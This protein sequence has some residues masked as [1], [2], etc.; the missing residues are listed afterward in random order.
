VFGADRRDTIFILDCSLSM[1]DPID[2]KN[3][4]GETRFQAGRKALSE[5]L[6]VLRDSPSVD[7]ERDPYV[8]GFMA[9]GH[10]ARVRD[11]D[12]EKTRTN[13][14]WKL[15]I[16]ATVVDDWRNDFDLMTPPTRL[17]DDKYQQILQQLDMLQPYGETPL[18]GAIL[19][20][21][22][23]LVDRQR[24]GVVVAI[25]DGV[26]NDEGPNGP[27]LV[28]LEDLFKK[29]PELSLHLVAYGVDKPDDIAKL[30]MTATR[31][32]G[33]ISTAPSG[34][35]LARTI[36]KV[37]KPRQYSVARNVEPREEFFTDLGDPVDNRPPRTYEVRFPGLA[38]MPVRIVGGERLEF[39]LDF[40][41]SRL[42]HR[43]PPL[44]LF[45]R[46]VDATSFS[47]T[48]PTRFGYLEADYDNTR[49]TATLQLGMDR[50][51]LLGTID[52]PAELRLDIVSRAD[53]RKF[54]RSLRLSPNLSIPAWQ[55]ELRGW[56][57][58]AQPEIQAVWKMSRTTPDQQQPLSK[59]L[60]APQKVTLPG[61]P[62]QSLLVKA[63]RQPGKLLLS[64][65]ADEGTAVVNVADVRVEIGK[66]SMVEGVFLPE[67]LPWRS[68]LYETE[69]QV[70][71]EFDLGDGL[72]IDDL[73][74]ALTSAESL[75][76]DARRLESPLVIEKWDREQ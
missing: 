50:D 73:R 36:A 16:P 39:D 29:H 54:S 58:D 22:R 51:D 27:R 55:V 23:T 19:S 60:M 41:A 42:R 30:T 62:E 31:M 1:A 53:R 65:Q 32:G 71:Y 69:R 13:D 48:E 18:L 4:N 35:D 17:S 26:Y 70:T 24:G 72:N 8:V 20:A 5:A 37:M 57:S 59:L 75:N 21:A 3:K 10:R 66:L 63:E 15:P 76:R 14:D 67:S 11:R 12:R 56:P 28:A 6:R 34:A 52:R 68:R 7:N 40:S 33:K 49:K 44:L 47:A 74:V 45:R 43:R 64:L 46:A 38:S 9:Y 2:A 61:W 25:T